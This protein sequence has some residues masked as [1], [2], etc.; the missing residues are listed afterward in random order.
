MS[1]GENKRRR[2]RQVNKRET[3]ALIPTIRK[4]RK[5]NVNFIIS[6]QLKVASKKVTGKQ[7]N[8]FALFKQA[9]FQVPADKKGLFSAK[10]RLVRLQYQKMIRKSKKKKTIF[11]TEVLHFT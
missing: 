1:S 4:V 8:V 9:R 10:D 2:P 6:E 11:W 3:R 5:K 7:K